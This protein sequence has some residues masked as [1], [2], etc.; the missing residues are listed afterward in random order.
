M[1]SDAIQ[2]LDGGLLRDWRQ[3]SG[4]HKYRHYQNEFQ[5][6]NSGF[7]FPVPWSILSRQSH[8][9]SNSAVQCAVLD[10]CH[11]FTKQYR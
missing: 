10:L 8:L 5:R 6:S 1:Q 11:L 2:L 7:I 4:K 3:S 9:L